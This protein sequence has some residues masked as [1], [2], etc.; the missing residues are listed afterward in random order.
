MK[1]NTAVTV[2]FFPTVTGHV[3]AL[4][5]QAPRHSMNTMPSGPWKGGGTSVSLT[6]VFVGVVDRDATDV[7]AV[8]QA[9]VV[10]DRANIL[11]VVALQVDDSDGEDRDALAG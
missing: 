6:S 11:R 9:A 10:L 3:A 2:T 1:L 8:D 7:R 4:P 5:V